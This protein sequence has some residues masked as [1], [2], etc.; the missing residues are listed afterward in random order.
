MKITN[1]HCHRVTIPYRNPYRMAPGETRHKKQIIVVVDTDEGISGV[2][3]TGVT[4]IER[5]GETQEAIYITIKRY[6]APLLIGMDPFDIGLVIDRL[7]GFNQGRTGFLCA[8]AAIDH[9]LYDIMGKAV[10]QPVAKLL[11]GIHRTQFKVSRS[12]GVKTPKEMA[13]D[14]VR[15]K[16][17]GYAMLTIK[18]GFDVKED[19]E[20]VA[21]VRDA[22][23]SGYPLEV[24]VNGAYNVEVAIPVLRKME[25]YGIEAIEQPVPWWDLQGM[26]E[27]RI[28]LDTPITADESAWT[29]HDVANIARMGAADTICVKPVKNG[30]LFLSRRMAE[31]AEGAGM[32]VLMGSKHPLS[33]GASAILHFAAALPC[34][35][36]VLGYGSPLE[37][38]VDDICDPPL[39]MNKD[40]T[41]SLPEGPG[42][43]VTLSPE[44]LRKYTDTEP[45]V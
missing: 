9:A 31:M 44:K 33:P 24:D 38:L 40:G 37:R 35:H 28:A 34:V 4:L 13:E 1:V 39:E 3:E 36:G 17:M 16:S 43:G 12:L 27:V 2:G 21:A 6:F 10:N 41:V 30:G 26:K 18:V 8:K 32:G 23:G 14:A 22:V 25:R 20:R 45:L 29:P 15:L 7:E 19:I 42:L 5:G 11:G